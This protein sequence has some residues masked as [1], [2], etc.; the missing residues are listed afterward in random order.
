MGRELRRAVA[1]ATFALCASAAR[2]ELDETTLPLRLIGTVVAARADRSLAVVE[3]GGATRVVH[4]GDEVA[5]ARV[6]E[7]GKDAIVLAHAS[8][9]ERLSF[10]PPASPYPGTS[11][12]E[13]T[14]LALAHSSRADDPRETEPRA[15]PARRASASGPAPADKPALARARGAPPKTNDEVLAEVAKQARF[16]PLLDENGKLRGVALLGVAS[17]SMLERFGLQSGDVVTHVAGVKIDNTAN[18]YNTLRGLNLGNG[19]EVT[20]LRRG[21]VTTVNVPGSAF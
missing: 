3:S 16:K 2:A 17:D 20:V 8:R 10:A 18:A 7:I 14:R 19:V 5:G 1:I 11:E 9:R 4:R 13:A 12:E 15:R 6:E 21:S